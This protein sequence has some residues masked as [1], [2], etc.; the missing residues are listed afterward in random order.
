[1]FNIYHWRNVNLK[2]FSRKLSESLHPCCGSSAATSFGVNLHLIYTHRL[3]AQLQSLLVL[4]WFLQCVI[5]KTAISTKKYY[6]HIQSFLL[7]LLTNNTGVSY[8]IFL[9]HTN[10]HTWLNIYKYIIIH[11]YIQMDYI[12][13]HIQVY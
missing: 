6:L 7:F 2:L 1:M 4:T 13:S 10:I 8:A 11:L 5:S 3:A 9:W 12:Q